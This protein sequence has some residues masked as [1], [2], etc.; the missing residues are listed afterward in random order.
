MLFGDKRTPHFGKGFT[1]DHNKTNSGRISLHHSLFEAIWETFWK[2][3][4]TLPFYR[5]LFHLI[6][7][8]SIN[9][10]ECNNIIFFFY[11]FGVMDHYLY[12]VWCTNRYVFLFLEYEKISTEE[13]ERV[14]IANK[15]TKGES[16][17][18]SVRLLVIK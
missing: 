15:D 9:D 4:N 10:I 17:T 11:I 14:T 12:N 3:S 8:Q 13:S 6:P 5:S 7:T 18:K 2:L 16:H 1:T